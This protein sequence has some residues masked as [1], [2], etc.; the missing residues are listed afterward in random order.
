MEEKVMA[1]PRFVLA[2]VLGLAILLG[3]CGKKSQDPVVISLEGRAVPLSEL[4]FEYNRIKGADQWQKA[5]EEARR[6]FVDTFAQKEL[7]ARNAEKEYGMEL[8]G[9]ERIIFDR[10]WEKQLN[11]RYWKTWREAIPLRQSVIDSLRQTLK[12]ERY[13]RQVVTQDETLAREIYAKV[14]AGGAIEEIGKEY[15]ARYPTKVAWADVRWVLRTRLADPIAAMLFDR[16][17]TEGEVGEPVHSERYGWHVIELHGIRPAEE[18]AQASEA[19]LISRRLIRGTAVARHTE[20]L[21][22]KYAARVLPEG[23]DPLMRHLAAM[24]DSLTHKTSGVLVDFQGLNPPF[25]RFTQAEL[26]LPLVRWAGETLTVGQ[27]LES[28]RKIDLD[29]WP[30]VGDTAKINLQIVRRMDRLGQLREA[31]AARTGEDPEFQRD[32]RRTRQE[33]YLDRFQR[34]HLQ[35]YS[36]RITEADAAAYWQRQGEEYRSR[37]LVAYSFLRFP[38]EDK[39]LATRISQNLQ[40]GV[41]WARAAT[42]ARKADPNVTS[43]GPVDP[44]DGPPFPDVTEQ[45]LK[46]DV[47]PNGQ[48]TVTEPIQ[49]SN[50]W[51]ILKI[52]FR[53]R[54][55]TL[56]YEKAQPFV[57]RD[58]QRSAMEDTLKTALGDLKKSLNLKINWKV[59]A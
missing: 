54:P 43:E 33:L 32:V 52:V 13:L 50:D 5:N 23:L 30:T 15:T 49:I 44:T 16:L 11:A 51:V 34:E 24:Y 35:K 40:K 53:A 7:L 46:Y 21:Q 36:D 29:F 38:P 4:V 9:R 57:L 42:E 28:L 47:Q 58:L 12:E 37:D 17:R 27:F 8:S 25:E 59:I 26:A 1:K 48:P 39:D 6:K 2:G 19:D 3:A 45:A 31:E 41:A 22:R 56:S 55:E 18:A 14:R 20:E 10:W